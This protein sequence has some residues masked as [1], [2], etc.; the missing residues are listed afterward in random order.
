MSKIA[1]V[2]EDFLGQKNTLFLSVALI[3]FSLLRIPSVIEPYWYGDEGI[4]EVIGMA[5]SQGRILY[6]EIWDNKPPLLY[7]IYSLFAGDQFYVRLLSLIF[8]FLSVAVIFAILRK[9]FKNPLAIALPTIFFAFVFGSPL[10]EGNVANAENFLILP[11]LL[12][13]YFCF[14]AKKKSVPFY[15]V[16]GILFSLAFLIKIVALFDFIA[17]IYII[18]IY[19]LPKKIEIKSKRF[20]IKSII[21]NLWSFKPL[22]LG[23]ISPIIVTVLY[24]VAVGALPEFL[25]G[26]FSQNVGYV[27]YGNFF[28][29]KN[30]ELYLKIIL[31]SISL[32]LIFRFRI[33]LGPVAVLTLTWLVFELFSTFFSARP[34]THYL[35]VL[36]PS[37]TVL[38]ALA[39]ENRKLWI[40]TIPL[41]IAILFLINN[42]F[43]VHKKIFR[44]YSNYFKYISGGSVEE[45]RS[46][47]DKNMN[48]D[49]DLAH[50]IDLK[51]SDNENVFLWSDSSQ[52]YALS[53]K[54][55][56]GRYVVAYHITGNPGAIEETKK[57]I[58]KS[59]PKY[60]IQT[61]NDPAISNF[62]DGY[63]LQY[64][65]DNSK[66]Y[67]RQP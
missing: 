65:I 3:L 29:V 66:I 31:L 13:F 9:I 33:K 44:Y 5:L 37:F 48:R 19:A 57:A 1:S 39:I 21:N 42:N 43:Q 32:L 58:D 26:A 20:G 23:F 40:V 35:L 61:K 50:F 47:F 4:Y 27:A 7:V 36:L 46:S 34:Y 15:L 25:S 60:I 12:A 14:A 2:I 22:I 41:V 56:P 63:S 30:G 24:F 67:E 45:Y 55:P 49:Y 28:I 17:A 8:G 51:T 62:L 64:V 38:L 18:L 6:S 53:G 16:A 59:Q 10:I 52:I 11:I 54:L